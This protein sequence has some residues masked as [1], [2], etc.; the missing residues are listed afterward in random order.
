MFTTPR[1]GHRRNRRRG[2]NRSRHLS[3]FAPSKSHP[4]LLLH[5]K[6]NIN[7]RTSDVGSIAT[8]E[9]GLKTTV[10]RVDPNICVGCGACVEACPYRAITVRNRKAHIN[11]EGC[12]GC[13]ACMHVCPQGAIR[14]VG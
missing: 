3:T 2:P 5:D 10:F 4:L 11:H 7:T 8:I 1:R 9:K 12:L 14:A 13:G 6:T